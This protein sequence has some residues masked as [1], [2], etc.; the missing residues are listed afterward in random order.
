MKFRE[1]FYL[2]GMKP[3]IRHY[4]YR[5]D[6]F[7]LADGPIEFANWNSPV[8]KGKC[9]TQG[10]IDALLAFVKPGDTVI[11]VGAQ[12]GDTSVP[13]GLAVGPKGCVFA[14]EPNPSTHEVLRVNARLNPEKVRIIPLPFAA[15]DGPGKLVFNYSDPS[16]S[17]GGDLRRWSRWRHSHAFEIEVDGVHA[18]ALLR[19]QYPE[20]IKRLSYIKVDAEGSDLRV[21][22]SMEGLIREFS[23]YIRCEVYKHLNEAQRCEIFQYLI[24]LGYLLH[25]FE[26]PENY[27]GRSLGFEDVSHLP[28]YDIF[29]VPVHR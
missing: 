24:D 14:F 26:G 20:E 16:L 23:P 1:I 9:I 28:H 19:E 11:D 29:A 15:S 27:C 13:M 10:Q 22:R 17:N 12:I 6:S 8:E 21:L 5:I 2:L 4:G 7:E 3:A 18:E 25:E